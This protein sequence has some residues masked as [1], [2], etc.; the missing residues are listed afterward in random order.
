M[1]EY[2]GHLITTDLYYL[3]LSYCDKTEWVWYVS[4]GLATSNGRGY[5][6]AE[7]LTNDQLDS[8]I[9]SA[10]QWNLHQTIYMDDIT[11]EDIEKLGK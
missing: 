9:N 6:L 3:I 5:T 2:K 8:L 7:V 1:R 4:N 11:L 10:I